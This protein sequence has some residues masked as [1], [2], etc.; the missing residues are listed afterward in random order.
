MNLPV[1]QLIASK[2]LIFAWKCQSWYKGFSHET[3]F[4]IGIIPK[5]SLHDFSGYE[6]SCG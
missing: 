3:G 1:Q 6:L 5:M 4:S 2:P